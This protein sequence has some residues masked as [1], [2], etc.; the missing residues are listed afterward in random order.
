MPP[1]AANSITPQRVAAYGLAS[2]AAAAGVV[3]RAFRER[4]NFYAATVWLGRS[5]GC[6]LVL[7]NFALFVTLMLGKVFQQIFFGRLRAVEVEHLYERSWYSL[8]ETLLAMTLFRDEFDVGFVLLFGTLLFLKVF[9]W[10]SADRVE[11]MEQTP[12]VS[13]LFH[14]RMVSILGSLLIVDVVLVTFAVEVLLFENMRLGIMVLFASEFIILTTSLLSTIAKYVINCQD[15]RSEEPWEA[16]SM[17]VFYVD[18]ATDFLKLAT[19]VSFFILLTTWYGL[20]LSLIRDLYVTGRSCIGKVR[21]LIRYRA[22]TRNMDSRYPDAT[23]DD[24][25]AMSDGTCIICREDMVVSGPDPNASTDREDANDSRP[26]A[27]SNSGGSALNATPKKLPCGH[28]FH[29][30]CL[31]SWLERQQSCPT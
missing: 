19:Y 7:L 30:H 24:M 13:N 12:S 3:V 25:R 20:P 1:P 15:L 6:M 22:A 29:F 5:N 27:M 2:T 8:S 4:S 10:L 21:D 28:I 14:A 16:K 31:R 18:L 9:H 23:H 11:F 17:Y 26:S